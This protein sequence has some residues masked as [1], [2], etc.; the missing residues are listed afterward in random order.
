MSHAQGIATG[1]TRFTHTFTACAE[2]AMADNNNSG[3][4]GGMQCLAKPHPAWNT[5]VLTPNS[6][7]AH[8]PK[9]ELHTPISNVQMPYKSQPKQ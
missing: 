5:P 9:T 7:A 8:A 4:V 1:L 6:Q 2:A 3:A